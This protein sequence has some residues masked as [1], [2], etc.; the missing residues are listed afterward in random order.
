M[1]LPLPGRVLRPVVAEL[2]DQ[3]SATRVTSF[4][5]DLLERRFT[6]N[7]DPIPEAVVGQLHGVTAGEVSWTYNA[8]IKGGGSITVVETGQDIDWA[9]A[10]IRPVAILNDATEIPIGV[11]I[12][13]APKRTHTATGTLVPVELLDKCSLLD[14][15]VYADTDTGMALPF[16]L[17]VGSDVLLTVKSLIEDVGEA[18]PLIPP[19]EGILTSS[20]MTWD[21]GTT[22]LRIINDL[23][24]A[25][26]YFS[27]WV[28][29]TG[30]FRTTKYT[31]PKD[32]PAV[33]SL[34]A[35]F[36]DGRLMSPEWN[37]EEDIYSIPN[38]FVA[39][40]QGDDTKEGLVS[41]AML[42]PASPYSYA[43][44]G[45]WVT[46]VATGVEVTDQE[47]LDKYAA[48]RLAIAV[49]VSQRIE[50]KHPIL[51]N[52]RVNEN[53]HFQAGD[54]PRLLCSIYKTSVVFDPLALCI[55]ELSEA[56]EVVEDP[57]LTEPTEGA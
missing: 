19:D 47:A 56:A 44:R 13:S 45:R 21:V 33:Y 50:V 48:W 35:P 40:T 7:G 10:R 3:L 28:D 2:E 27:L 6:A 51:P 49:S 38:R 4:R 18:T 46:A 57:T 20:P 30:A 34:L 15:D 36:E 5:F 1:P 43:N 29:G 17:A 53:I 31:P 42:D 52:L 12:P 14:Q 55:T 54:G 39:I 11:F 37:S 9:T 16:S 22:R 24:S 23:L 8:S 32:R 26:N 25:I 41:T